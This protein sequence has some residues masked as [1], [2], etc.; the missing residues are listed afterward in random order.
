MLCHHFKLGLVLTV[1]DCVNAEFQR[2]S[3]PEWTAQVTAA[4]RLVISK[5]D[6][7][8]QETYAALGMSR[9]HYDLFEVDL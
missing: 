4:D 5:V 8:D 3:F 6:L 1:V 9:S 2:E 7:V